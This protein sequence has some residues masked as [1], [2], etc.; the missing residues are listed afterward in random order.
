MLKA[1]SI[2]LYAAKIRNLFQN[3]KLRHILNSL[4]YIYK[5]QIN[6]HKIWKIRIKLIT[7]RCK[8]AACLR[9]RRH[10]GTL[11]TPSPN[12]YRH[13]M[14]QP[15][16]QL[17]FKLLHFSIDTSA[18]VPEELEH[19]DWAELYDTACCQAVCGIIF[20]GI[21][22]LPKHLM[23]PKAIMLKFIAMAE[24][25]KRQN[26]VLNR[27]CTEATERLQKAGFRCCILKGQGNALLYPEPSMRTPG[28]IDVWMEG[29]TKRVAT[30]VN[31]FPGDH[32]LCY[33][34]IQ[35]LPYKGTD[36]EAHFR[37]AFL[38][39]ALHNHRLQR[40]FSENADL[41]FENHTNLP[42]EEGQVSIPTVE[43]NIVQQASHIANH[44]F[45]EGVGMRQIID[46]Y[47]LVRRYAALHQGDTEAYR[48][49][50]KLLCQLGLQGFAAAIMYVLGTVFC[51]PDN[52]MIVTPDKKRG[53]FLLN[54][55][56]LS[57]NF[58]QHDDRVPAIMRNNAIGRNVQR[59]LRD[60]R[61][62]RWFPAESLSEPPFRLWHF[63]WRKHYSRI[64]KGTGR[65]RN[66]N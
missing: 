11:Q 17:F 56:I 7:S 29:G 37:P 28:D 9:Q 50:Q 43:F 2:P 30:F 32:E 1:K 6:T 47:L 10:G 61:L 19:V 34:H 54:E 42:G 4:S 22:R 57:G 31:R 26:A 33:H 45:H 46:Y 63:F 64:T 48:Q 65:S 23:P 38:N 51:L 41:Q 24:I 16:L 58:G 20:H 66:S 25:I 35:M 8:H 18:P 44:F 39:N 5:T 13:K 27:H 53:R 60:L 21:S 55:I 49:T 12:T 40:F 36:V 62:M 52:E 59:L 14:T 3:S 15:Q